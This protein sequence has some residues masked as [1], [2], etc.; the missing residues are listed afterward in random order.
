VRRFF[1]ATGEPMRHVHQQGPHQFDYNDWCAACCG[2]VAP[3]PAWRKGLWEAAG[4]LKREHG[5]ASYRDRWDD[6]AA[7]DAAHAAFAPALRALR[8]APSEEEADEVAMAEEEAMAARLAALYPM[9]R[10]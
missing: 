1:E 2:D 10:Y 9:N 7:A 6:G 5:T 8:E 3:T 4:R